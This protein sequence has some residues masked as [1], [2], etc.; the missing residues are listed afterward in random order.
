MTSWLDLFIMHGLNKSKNRALCLYLSI[1]QKF[2]KFAL[3]STF[4][5]CICLLS[6]VYTFVSDLDSADKLMFQIDF[7]FIF[8]LRYL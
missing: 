4:N 1:M 5:P 2:L 6:I 3:K 8:S 7:V